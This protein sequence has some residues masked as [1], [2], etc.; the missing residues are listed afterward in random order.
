MQAN[1]LKAF[2][3][4]N[5]GQCI[6][7]L[8]VFEIKTEAVPFRIN[9]GVHIDTDGH[10]RIQLMFFAQSDEGIQFVV[11]VN[12]DEGIVA[13]GSNEFLV[14]LAGAVEMILLP[15]TPL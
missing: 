8:P 1:Q 5:S 2:G 9:A 11:M 4:Q 12:V 13:G 3:M 10:Q 15:G 7:S 6:P 14:G